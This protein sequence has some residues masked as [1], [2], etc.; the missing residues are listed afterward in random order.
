MASERDDFAT[1]RHAPARLVFGAALRTIP[2][3]PTDKSEE[4]MTALP[5]HTVLAYNLA[6]NSE[7]K[8]H[9]DSVAK[10]FGF[11]GGLVP[12]VDVFAYMSHM[13]VAKWGRDF[14]A[15]GWMT[16]RFLK[17]V[18]DGETAVVTAEEAGGGLAIKVESRGELCA[19]GQASMPSDAPAIALADFESAAP[20]A[21]RAP[22]DANSYKVGKWLGIPP[23]TL[24]AEPSR[25]YLRDIRETDPLYAEAGIV[26]PGMLLRTMNW[27]LMENAILGPWIHVGSTIRY[28]AAASVDDALTVRAKVTANDERKGHKFVELDGLIVANGT[29]PVARCHHVAIYQ[30]RET[31]AA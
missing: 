16:G 28:L 19:S 5:P 22:V 3:N 26:H 18:Y 7:N 29:T 24:G 30:P 21:T 20:V 23:F 27:A 31:M 17:P 12:G 13:P 4:T 15:R 6:K 8:M 2:A 14:L 25:D 11:Q 10:R 1:E 9:D